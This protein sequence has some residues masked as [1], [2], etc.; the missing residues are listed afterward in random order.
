MG[1]RDREREKEGKK[2]VENQRKEGEKGKA[3]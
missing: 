1:E 2:L 3:G